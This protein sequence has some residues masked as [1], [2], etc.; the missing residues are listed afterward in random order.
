MTFVRFLSSV[1]ETVF[2]KVRA[3]DKGIPT[4]VALV[5][6]LSSVSHLMPSE[7]RA[8]AEG[9]PTEMA[10]IRFTPGVRLPTWVRAGLLTEG[11]LTLFADTGF[12][13][14]VI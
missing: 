10:L 13:F 12:L 1:C 11:V 14:R 7:A 4:E 9:F 2:P 6:L 8:V 5:W 3:L